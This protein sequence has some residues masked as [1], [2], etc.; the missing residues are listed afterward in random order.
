MVPPDVAVGFEDFSRLNAAWD[1]CRGTAGFDP[2]AD[3]DANGCNGYGHYTIM[4]PNYG[5]VGPTGW[6]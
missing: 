3:F 1:R 6:Q 2:A 4:R 5:R